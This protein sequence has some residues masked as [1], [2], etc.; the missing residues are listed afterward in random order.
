MTTLN[1]LRQRLEDEYLEPVM[2]ETP[3][4]PATTDIDSTQTAFT[5]TSGILSPDEESYIAEGSTIEWDSELMR[6]VTYNE[7]TK[8][9][10]VVRNVRNTEASAHTT[11][12]WVRIPTRWTRKSQLDA[13][14]AGIEALWQP[15]FVSKEERTILEVAGYVA[16]PLN[17]V[18]LIDVRYQSPHSRRWRSVSAEL[19]ATHPEDPTRAAIQVGSGPDRGQLCVIRYGVAIEPPVG[20]DDEIVDLPSKYE[21]IVLVDAAAE[22]LSSVDIDAQ[23]QEMLTEKMRLENF[24]VR[25]GSQIS[26]SLI[27]YREYL[28]AQAERELIAKHPR[29][30]VNRTAGAWRQA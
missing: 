2:E 20:D 7:L 23:S 11:A 13:L 8:Q 9:I 21:R 28:V 25:S 19:F 27:R 3:Q 16:L 6:V 17:T 12:S 4:V 29:R 1:D 18:R 15:L 30:I 22:L 24:P 14:R 5:L 26:Q 10:T